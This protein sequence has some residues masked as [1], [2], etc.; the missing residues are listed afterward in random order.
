MSQPT[1][2]SDLSPADFFLFLKLKTL[3]KEEPFATIEEKK[4]KI[5]TGA[6]G[7]NKK[8]V[9]RIGKTAN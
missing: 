3:M 2:S 6:V 5:E 1:H 8:R 9:S 4:R 7:D